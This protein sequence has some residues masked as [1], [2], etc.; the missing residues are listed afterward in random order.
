MYIR[1]FF[2]TIP[3]PAAYCCRRTQIYVFYPFLNQR[4]CFSRPSFAQ[5]PLKSFS[6]PSAPPPP[7]ADEKVRKRWGFKAALF[8]IQEMRDAK[9]D[10]SLVH[11]RGAVTACALTRQLS[12]VLPLL[13]EMRDRGVAA[14]VATYDAA[15]SSCTTKNVRTGG[16][17]VCRCKRMPTE[18]VDP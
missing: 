7:G 3:S 4:L 9:L 16:G 8:L 2:T 18:S 14:D 10:I 5:L 6:L 12:G 11:Y 17:W 1:I 15:I 13:D